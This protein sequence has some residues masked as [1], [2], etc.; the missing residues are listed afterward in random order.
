MK[1]QKTSAEQKVTFYSGKK[2]NATTKKLESLLLAS[3]FEKTFS[4]STEGGWNHDV[5]CFR[6][7]F[8]K[9][10][11]KVFVNVTKPKKSTVPMSYADYQKQKEEA[12]IAQGA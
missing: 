11:E 12:A 3:G 5:D 2:E 9:G 7:E 6:L 8:T 10:N 1:K 4:G